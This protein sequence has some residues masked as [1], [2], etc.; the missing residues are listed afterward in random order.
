MLQ[1]GKPLQMLGIVLKT[2]TNVLPQHNEDIACVYPMVKWMDVFTTFF[3]GSVQNLLG[4]SHPPC[5]QSR[6]G[7]CLKTPSS[8]AWRPGSGG[9]GREGVKS[10]PI[11]WIR[12]GVTYFIGAFLE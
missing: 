5:A 10:A 4:I 11:F 2:I 3:G 9:G 12:W 7:K 1:R 8:V 6:K